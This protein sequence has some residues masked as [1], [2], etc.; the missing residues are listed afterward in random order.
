M[1]TL[2]DPHGGS[3]FIFLEEISRLCS[4]VAN[5]QQSQKEAPPH[6]INPHNS[7]AILAYD[8]ANYQLWETALDRTLWHVFSKT[9]SFMS[10]ANNFASL[11]QVESSLVASLMQNTLLRLINYSAPATKL[12]ISWDEAV[13]ILLQSNFNPPVGVEAKNFE[14]SVD[15]QLNEQISPSFNDVST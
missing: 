7:K 8:G 10:D 4:G 15:Q 5:I 2:R 3:I 6:R 12:T 14:F 1:D 11:Q 9:S 13:G